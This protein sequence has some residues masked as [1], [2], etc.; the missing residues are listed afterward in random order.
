MLLCQAAELFTGE[1]TDE[2]ISKA[3]E[4]VDSIVLVTSIEGGVDEQGL[5]LATDLLVNVTSFLTDFQ[6]V[7]GTTAI[8]QVSLAHSTTLSGHVYV[9]VVSQ[10]LVIVEVLDNVL[11][12]NDEETMTDKV[13]INIITSSENYGSF[14]LKEVGQQDPVMI[15]K[16]NISKVVNKM[17]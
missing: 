13:G 11:V 5:E 14:L 9:M 4:F 16:D 6:D 7:G 12:P 3:L 17:S 2:S 10:S 1:P 15:L 8:N